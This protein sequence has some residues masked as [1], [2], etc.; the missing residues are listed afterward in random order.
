MPAPPVI[1]TP[2]LDLRPWRATDAPALLPILEA[3]QDHFASWI[4][5]AVSEPV[6]VPVLEAR[7]EA[8]AEDFAADRAWRYAYLLRADDRLL[9]EVSLFPRDAQGRVALA[10]ADR[11]EIGYWLRRDA[12]GQGLATEAARAMLDLARSLPQVRLVEI[13]CD[14]RNAPSGAVAHRLGFTLDRIE[15]REGAGTAGA[16]HTH[17]WLYRRQA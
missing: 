5:R 17:V 1:T 12:T 14:P 10:D 11:F 4:P 6:S 15:T 7:L 3:N 2:R 9:G 16:L 8:R 13:R